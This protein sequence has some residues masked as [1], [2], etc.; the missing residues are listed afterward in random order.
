MSE[1]K[2][3]GPFLTWRYCH[4]EVGELINSTKRQ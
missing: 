4:D 1:L 3:L 2:D